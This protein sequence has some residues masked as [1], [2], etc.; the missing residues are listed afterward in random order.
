MTSR[1]GALKSLLDRPGLDV[2]PSCHDALSARLIERA[3]FPAAFM[4]GFA[5]SAARLAM[6]DTGL[7]SYAEMV[8]QGRAICDAVSLPVM[9]D[10]DTGFG[11]AANVKRTVRGF[12]GAGF[13][14][15][16]IED[17][18]SPKRCGWAN[19][20]AV[21]DRDETVRRLR[22]AIDARDEGADTLI[23][24]RTDAATSMGFAEGL[25]RAEAFQD[26]GCDIIY[27]E[28]ADDPKELEEFCRRV[29]RPKLFVKAEGTNHRLPDDALLADLGFRFVVWAVT[30]LN[31]S[32]RAME[33]ALAT[34]RQGGHPDRIV[35]FPHLNEVVGLDDFYAEETRYAGVKAP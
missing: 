2:I 10:A 5:T 32:V 18:V 35:S 31:V 17:Q 7:I 19:G 24:G 20:V 23:I 27:L 9:G 11:G 25:W 29:H 3:G 12:A 14:A 33:D 22:A 30:L 21:V 34:M 6:P 13:A 28:G 15:T 26:M 8:D 4:S 16:M 1:T